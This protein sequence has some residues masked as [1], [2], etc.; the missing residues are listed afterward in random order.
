MFEMTLIIALGLLGGFAVGLQSPIAGAIGLR[1]G[2]TASSF[3]LHMSG[4]L[5]SG[6][7]LFLRG[8]EKVR[9]WY[10]LPWYMLGSGIF[11]L[12]LFLSISVTLPRL[13][14]TVMITLIICGQL[15]AGLL[16][17]QFGWFGV[18]LHPITLIRVCGAALLLLGGFLIG[19]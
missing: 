6:F 9:D 11:G 19:R 1:I 5:L 12:I 4:M 7:L 8:G 17:D 2:P 18:P 3:I 15:L 10:H 16:I 13:G 14:A